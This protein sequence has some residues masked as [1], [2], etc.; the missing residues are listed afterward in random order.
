M[1]ISKLLTFSV[2]EGASDCHI[3][4]GEPPMIRLNGDL[5]R[6]DHPALTPEET[7]ALVYDR[8]TSRMRFLL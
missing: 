4:A 6:L 7:H 2:K 5:K 3:S 1:D 8:G